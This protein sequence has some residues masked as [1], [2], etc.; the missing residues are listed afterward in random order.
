MRNHERSVLFCSLARY[1]QAGIP[2][3]RGLSEWVAQ[4]PPADRKALRRM[5]AAV[6]SG[7]PFDKAGLGSGVLLPW[8][9]RLLAVGATHGRL[10]R[11]LDELADFHRDAT[12]W[13]VRLRLRLLF[14]GAVLLLGWLALPLPRLIAGEL[15]VGTYLVQNLLLVVILVLSW[16]HL[17]RMRNLHALLDLLL[18]LGVIGKPVWHYRR[19][20]FLGQLA[21]LHDAGLPM[22]DALQVAINS[23]DSA[24]L[25]WQWSMATEAVRQGSGVSEALYH[26]RALDDTGYALVISGESSGRLGEMLGREASRLGKGVGLWL[27][28]LVDWLPRFAYVLVL[29]LLFNR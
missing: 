10:D 11:T 2:L 18:P 22:L 15:H 12:D 17:G 20:R 29:L 23:I 27:S 5:A 14:P 19:Y 21:R 26:Y 7:Q 24:Y 28:G 3:D 6:Q 4:I 1:H 16:R 13:W 9:A 8:E 25:R